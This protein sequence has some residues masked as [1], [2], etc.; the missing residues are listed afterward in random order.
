MLPPG[1]TASGFFYFHTASH[2]GSILYVTGIEEAATGQELFFFEIP[3][4]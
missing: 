3:L 2:A 1:D 4:D